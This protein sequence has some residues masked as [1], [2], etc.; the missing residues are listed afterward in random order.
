MSKK[1]VAKTIAVVLGPQTW[2]PVLLFVFIL[3]TGLSGQ[4]I[5]ILLPLMFVFLVLVPISYLYLAPKLKWA[6]EWDLP[7]KKDR[8]P[9]FA[10]ITLSSALAM[11]LVY[12]LGNQFLFNLIGIL[13]ILMLINSLITYFWKI[14]LHT[15]INTLGPILVNFLFDWQLPFLYLGIPIIFWAR[16]NLNKHTITQL[17]AGILV[18]ALFLIAALYFVGYIKL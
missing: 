9:F 3:K 4:Q 2:L 18:N 5:K 17:F 14:S 6:K 11:L 1:T 12:Y 7:E 10:V 16:R 15:G 13:F 8:I